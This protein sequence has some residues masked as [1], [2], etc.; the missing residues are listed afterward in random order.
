VFICVLRSS[1]FWLLFIPSLD[2]VMIRCFF[3]SSRRRHTIFS[4]DWSSDVCSSDLVLGW[5]RVPYIWMGTLIQFG[6]FAIL[7][8]ALLVLSEIGRA[9]CRERALETVAPG[10]FKI[11]DLHSVAYV[12]W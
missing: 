7:P 8:F 11:N 1:W 3:F 4:R 9:S 6:G 12:A 5:R 2:R 10:S